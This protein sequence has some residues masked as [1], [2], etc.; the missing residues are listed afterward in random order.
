MATPNATGT[1]TSLP[2]VLTIGAYDRFNYGDLLFPLI[3]DELLVK[4]GYSPRHLS[5]RLRIDGVAGAPP[6]YKSAP[7]LSHRENS[8]VPLIIG[9]GE[10]LGATWTH[11]LGYLLPNFLGDPLARVYNRG[12]RRP[13]DFASRRVLGDKSP[14]PY[15]P[16]KDWLE[17]RLWS[18][19]AIGASSLKVLN[20]KDQMRITETLR[21]ANY[22]GVRD[23]SSVDILASRGIEAHLHPDSAAVMTSLYSSSLE[24]S[25]KNATFQCSMPW[26]R[27]HGLA[28]ATYA[29]Q[30]MAARFE[31]VLLIPIGLAGAHSDQFALRSILEQS[32]ERLKRQLTLVNPADVHEVRRRISTSELFV[33]SSLH[34]H[35][36]SMAYGVPAVALQG[37]PKLDQYIGTWGGD[38]T[39]L[40][41]QY[42]S[43]GEAIDKAVQQPVDALQKRAQELDGLAMEGIRR[44][45][46]AVGRGLR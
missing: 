40:E 24:K 21:S 14:G 12:F 20:A 46:S 8:H 41:G 22:V 27:E 16:K 10:V 37:I 4:N 43:I 32:D 7:V 35:I 13:L 36:T 6:T 30:A 19:N 18:T 45:A 11:T 9:G 2:R 28:N 29:V 33:G 25:G 3:L 26:L 44:A 15:V 39:P 5:M 34:G 42:P 38:L 23:Q 17:K 31:N 1:R